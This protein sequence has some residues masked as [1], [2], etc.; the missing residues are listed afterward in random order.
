[1]SHPLREAERLWGAPDGTAESDRLEVL[2]LLIEAYEKDRWPVELPDRVSAID[3]ALEQRGWTR[4]ALVPLLGSRDVV[5]EVMAGQRELTVEMIW[6]LRDGLGI[7][8]DVLVGAAP[9]G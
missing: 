8:A 4:D 2:I 9:T 7:S 1:M 5:D 3:F 6:R